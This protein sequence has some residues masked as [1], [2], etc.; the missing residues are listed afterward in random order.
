[1]T[2]ARD[3][4]YGSP[5][6]QTVSMPLQD[7]EG[8]KTKTA[9][10]G[11]PYRVPA[12]R[13]PTALNQQPYWRLHTDDRQVVD[14]ISRGVSVCRWVSSSRRCQLSPDCGT[15][16]PTGRD[17]HHT[18]SCGVPAGVSQRIRFRPGIVTVHPAGGFTPTQPQQSIYSNVHT[19][20]LVYPGTPW[21]RRGVTPAVSIVL[22]VAVVIVIASTTAAVVFTL[23]APLSDPAPTTTFDINAENGEVVIT[24]RGGDPVAV[25]ELA[26][27]VGET[28][29]DGQD[30]A[31]TN[32]T[33]RF[34]DAI[35]TPAAAEE[36]TVVY[37]PENEQTGTILADATIS[38]TELLPTL[39]E[40]DEE[41]LVINDTEHTLELVFIDEGGDSTLRVNGNRYQ[42]SEGDKF[43]L[44]GEDV[45]V[46]LI[47]E[48]AEIVAVDPPEE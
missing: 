48:E 14:W 46:V 37:A 19:I 35:T 24:H 8:K 13:Q 22:L 34:G 20:T 5:T 1:M 17:V 45:T 29:F 38:A 44:S 39:T 4:G 21:Q 9:K 31:A 36:I 10:L 16:T 15:T 43:R 11:G 2:L 40:G 27:T 42:Y 28:R 33:L 6:K 30:V 7:L 23:D 26:V 32:E 47:D 25:E 41:T 3:V 12:S 18:L